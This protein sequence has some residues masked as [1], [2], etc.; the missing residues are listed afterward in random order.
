MRCEYITSVCQAPGLKQSLE[1][2]RVA[3]AARELR[4][5]TLDDF[6]EETRG[7]TAHHPRNGTPEVN[8]NRVMRSKHQFGAYPVADVAL[9]LLVEVITL[10]WAALG[11]GRVPDSCLP[12]NE[13]RAA[14]TFLTRQK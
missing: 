13:G 3:P 2:L 1:V 7:K 6:T 11:S 10:C 9:P 5:T 4:S 12:K 8:E 14:V